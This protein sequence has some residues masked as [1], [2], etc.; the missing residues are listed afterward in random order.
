MRVS[1]AHF[2]QNKCRE[3]N[4]RMFFVFFF[5]FLVWFYLIRNLPFKELNDSNSATLRKNVYFLFVELKKEDSIFAKTKRIVF[6][7][8]RKQ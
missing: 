2:I 4:F 7:K 6:G 3:K 1:V 8:G 5:F